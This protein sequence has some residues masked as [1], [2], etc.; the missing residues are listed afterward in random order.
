MGDRDRRDRG[1]GEEDQRGKGNKRKK[2]GTGLSQISVMSG[3]V[4]LS[5]V[6]ISPCQ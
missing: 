4:I 2:K 6:V 5:S 3:A 1:G